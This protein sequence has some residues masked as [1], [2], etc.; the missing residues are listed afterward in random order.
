MCVRKNL[1]Y[2]ILEKITFR[3][4][5]LGWE[6]PL[7]KLRELWEYVKVRKITFYKTIFVY[8]VEIYRSDDIS[9]Y[10]SKSIVLF[11]SFSKQGI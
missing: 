1:E 7:R 10:G 4:Q 11:L 6:S 2:C 9:N 3:L 8:S 5:N